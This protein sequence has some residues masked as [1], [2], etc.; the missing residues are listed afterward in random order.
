MFTYGFVHIGGD[1]VENYVCWDTNADVQAFCK[2]MGFANSTQ[3]RSY[4]EQQVQAVVSSHGARSIAWEEVFDGGFYIA[5]D[6]II[7][8][9]A[10]G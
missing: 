1:E 7:N 3:L 4:Y 9:S 5:N 8:V 2:S 6:T 10:A